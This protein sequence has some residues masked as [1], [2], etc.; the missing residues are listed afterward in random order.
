[1]N[2]PVF[3]PSAPTKPPFTLPPNPSSLASKRQKA[4]GFPGAY[5]ASLLPFIPSTSFFLSTRFLAQILRQIPRLH[6]AQLDARVH[7]LLP[8]LQNAL[9]PWQLPGLQKLLRV[10]PQFGIA[11]SA[12]HLRQAN[13]G[14]RIHLL[15]NSREVV[16]EQ[17]PRR[18]LRFIILEHAGQRKHVSV[19]HLVARHQVKRL[20][21]QLRFGK[22]A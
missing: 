1:M 3:T 11:E 8:V 7:L 15:Q 16:L 18:R 19:L 2:W 9:R 13:R 12:R 4:P 5:A 22:G 14:R 21:R 6:R 17:L 20:L 10:V